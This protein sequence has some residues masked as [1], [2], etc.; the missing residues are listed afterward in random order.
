MVNRSE[1]EEV[2]D[3]MRMQEERELK[4]KNMMLP[5]GFFD[6]STLA[7]LT[8]GL[9]IGHLPFLGGNDHHEKSIVA[10]SF[11]GG[12]WT[13]DV[14]EILRGYRWNHLER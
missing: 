10:G 3:K 14:V 1:V 6:K 5:L 4:E 2:E 13:Q 8:L 9:V 7:W 12:P 11:V